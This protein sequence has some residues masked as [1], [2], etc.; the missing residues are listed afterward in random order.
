MHSLCLQY[1]GTNS[2]GATGLLTALLE[3][4]TGREE[5]L[6]QRLNQLTEQVNLSDEKYRGQEIR[7][8]ENETELQNMRAREREVEALL[9][10]RMEQV[11]SLETRSTKL[12]GQIVDLYAEL[13]LCHEQTEKLRVEL[14]WRD[15]QVESLDAQSK[16]LERQIGTYQGK[17]VNRDEQI[18]VMHRR[19]NDIIASRAW[20]IAN[21]LWRVRILLAPPSSLRARLLGRLGF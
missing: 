21:L 10:A 12:E 18:D 1:K 6:N 15:E 19:L 9:S 13:E 4:Q 8:A 17:L 5:D 20:R 14:A 3:W 11:E 2:P 7:L 16:V